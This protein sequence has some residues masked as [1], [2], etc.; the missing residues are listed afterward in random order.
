MARHS[1]KTLLP[2]PFT[3]SNDFES[4]VTH[5]ELLSQ[6]H[7]WQRKETV[8][9]AET[10]IDE[11][12]HYFTLRLQTSA[13]D[14]YRTLSEDSRK[15]YDETVKAFRQHYNEK[16][17]VFR[18]RLAKRVQQPGEK[19]TDFLGDLQ[20]LALKAYP[21]EST[22]IREHLILRGFLEGIENS[23]VRLYLRKNLGDA[24]MTLDRALER[25]LHIEAVTRIEEEDK[26]PRVSATQLK[27]NSQL[28]DSINEFVRTLQTNQPNR[29]ENQKFSSQGARPKEF[30][31]GSERSSRE[32]GDRN[33]STN[34]YT[35][36]SAEHRRTNYEIRARSPTP[37]GENRSR[38]PSHESR[39]EQ[40]KAAVSFERKNVAVAVS[41]TMH[42]GNAKIV[43]N[44]GAQITSNEIVR[45]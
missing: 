33:R 21:Q 13:I 25:A 27:K 8:S 28:L 3:G 40:S 5:F 12:P 39:A 1:S 34:S 36:S 19:L 37:G 11:R 18:G 2:E 38:D 42:L 32:N 45:F 16:P 14:F 10:K 31:R 15:S 29:Q 17:V 6:L 35:R 7:K 41:E 43:S 23:Q 9:G 4:C 44:V 26:E 30:L 24:D 22:E 20:T